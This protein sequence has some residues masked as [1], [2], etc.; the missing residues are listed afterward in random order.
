MLKIFRRFTGSCALVAAAIGGPNFAAAAG[1]PDQTAAAM[2]QTALT[3][4]GAME[5]LTSLTT[6]VGPRLAGSAAEKRAA[7]W[8][9][10]RF[11]KAGFDKV[12]IESFPIEHGWARGIE[13]AE[14][15]S[16]C[17]QPLVI[18]ALGGSVAT[19]HG[20]EAE[21]VL[22]KTYNEFL[23]APTNSLTGKI[24]VVTEPMVRARD[25]HGYGEL[26]K[27]RTAGPG[28]AARRG[29][30]AY[31]LRSLG[32][33][34]HRVPHTGI[35]DYPEDVPPIPAAALS[36]PDAEQLERLVGLGKPVRIRLMLTP[37]DL[38]PVT[39]QNVVAEI[40]GREKPD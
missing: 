2:A 28:E 18:T 12:W 38:G 20:I 16:P 37:R 19:P 25:G 40:K 14:V 34:S 6:E 26:N 17:P 8:A 21:I 23:A 35:T 9:K 1:T 11:E 29:A 32:T 3:N 5:I 7:A 22:F 33:D 31:L 24:A 39:S 30:V 15:T 13:K 27:M 10:A 4:S 36:V